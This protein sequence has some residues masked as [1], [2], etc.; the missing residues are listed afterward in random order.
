MYMTSHVVHNFCESRL[1]NYEPPEIYNAYT[2]LFITII[3]LIL[4]FPKSNV[5]YNV[6]CMLAFN[7]CASF[8]YHYTLSWVGKQADEISMIL[9]AYYGIWGLLKMYHVEQWLIN[10]CNGWNSIFMLSFIV[11]NT[12]VEYDYLFPPLFGLYMCAVLYLIYHVSAAHQ[13]AYKRYLAVSLV[14]FICWLISEIDCN[15]YTQ[16]G[17]V[18]WHLLFPM[19]FYRLILK[20]DNH[21]MESRRYNQILYVP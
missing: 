9:A 20:F 10:W 15:E 7:G 8:Y 21:L 16:F 5:F 2:S 12:I 4:G 17:H 1:T 13:Y 18:V 6:A 14:G 3:P 11:S 19:G